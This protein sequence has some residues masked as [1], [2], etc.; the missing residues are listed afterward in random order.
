[1][2]P[3][4]FLCSNGPWR[5]KTSTHTQDKNK[6]KLH[7][8]ITHMSTFNG[9]VCCLACFPAGQCL[10]LS[11]HCHLLTVPGRWHSWWVLLWPAGLWGGL[12]GL[13]AMRR[14]SIPQSP[15]P[16]YR[17]WPHEGSPC[18]EL[19]SHLSAWDRRYTEDRV[20]LERTEYAEME[21]WVVNLKLKRLTEHF[22]FVILL[23]LCWWLC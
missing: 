18:P 3:S 14:R 5:E 12:A 11:C 17:P 1:M 4:S 13:W 15:H 19:C 2:I 21:G 22:I 16:S 20:R 6:A 23:W 9:N 7:W 8:L 10:Y